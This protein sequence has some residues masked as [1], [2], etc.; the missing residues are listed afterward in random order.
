MGGPYNMN[1]LFNIL[2][3]NWLEWEWWFHIVMLL[4][5]NSKCLRFIPFILDK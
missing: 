1:T 3:Y 5:C 4:K 2:K